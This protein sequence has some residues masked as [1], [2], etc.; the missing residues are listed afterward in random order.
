VNSRIFASACVLLLGLGIPGFAQVQ[1]RAEEIEDARR[2][3]QARLW[4]ERQSPLVD[5]VNRLVERGLYEGLQSGKGANGAQL[6]LGGMR[7]G[8]GASFGVGYRRTDIWR[9]RIGYRVTGRGT[10]R[11]AYMLDFELDFQQLRTERSF[12]NLYTKYESSPQMD[13]YGRGPDSDEEDR[14]SYLLDDFSLDLNAGFEV[15]RNFNLGVTGGIYSANTGSGKR[16]G[17]PSIEEIFNPI[18]TPGLSQETDYFRWGFFT[19]LDYRDILGGARS[20][21]FYGL[22]FRRYSDEVKAEFSFEQLELQL[23][24][25]IPYFNRSRVIALQVKTV[26]SFTD[27]GE[28]VPFYLQPTLGGNDDLRGF[29]RYRFYD[30]NMIFATVEHRWHAFSGL[31]MALFVDGGKVV[32]RKEDIDFSNLLYSGGIGFRFKVQDAVIMRI[33]FAA[34]SEGFRWMWTFSDIFKVRWHSQ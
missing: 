25:F 34:G 31:D 14:T 30:N 22:R 24:Q 32:R 11:Q 20:G 9:D 5:H 21:G 4:P 15:L 18:N 7:S 27:L 3:K 26:M 29:E 13:Y 23:Q 12:V 33:D 16:G 17:V 19:S 1:T 8:Q 6:V 2:D 10:I 28:R